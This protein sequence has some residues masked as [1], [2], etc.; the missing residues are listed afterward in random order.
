MRVRAD[1]LTNA[2]LIGIYGTSAANV[3]NTA[4]S[5]LLPDLLPIVETNAAIVLW[6]KGQTLWRGDEVWPFVVEALVEVQPKLNAAAAATLAGPIVFDLDAARGTQLLLPHLAAVKQLQRLFCARGL[7]A[8]RDDDRAAA[9]TNLLA[10]TRLVT[11]WNPEPVEVSQ[12][13]HC[14]LVEP[15]YDLLWQTL[16]AGHWSDEQLARLRTEWT[17]ARFLA[18]YPEAA[19]YV[20]ACMAAGFAE[21]RENP[22]PSVGPLN[23][24][25][26]S[27]RLAWYEVSSHFRELYYRDHGT[28][29]DE[30]NVLIFYHDRESQ[31]QR[32][33]QAPSWV[34]MQKLPGITNAPVFQSKHTS[35]T[36]IAANLRQISM[37]A[38]GRGTPLIAQ[39]AEAEAR[40]RIILTALALEH[41]HNHQPDY[42]K[43]LRDLDAPHHE[44]DLLDFM[45]GHPLRYF[46]TEDGRFVLYSVGLDGEDNGGTSRPARGFAGGP[47]TKQ[48]VHFDIMWPRPATWRASRTPAGAL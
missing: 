35:A 29:Q 17:A 26:Q 36:Q 25:I 8:L 39:F 42:P 18:G 1:A 10:A 34:E 43:T 33:I 28:Y 46:P 6:K 40:R 5:Q 31:L 3:R 23:Q 19:A 16:A 48:P 38:M 9:W 21:H 2:G 44:T 20:G 47:F 27:P 12:L 13:V 37:A 45:D 7:L 14:A 32:A 4:I 11:A 15:A 22:L 30:K 24:L 41:H